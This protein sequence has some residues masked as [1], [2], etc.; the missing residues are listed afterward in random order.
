[1]SKDKGAGYILLDRKIL[2][3]WIY[4]SKPFNMTMAWIDMLLIATHTTH[5]DL[6]RGV[7]TEFKRGDVNLS[8][9][10]L[11]A[12]WGWSR[13]KAKRFLKHLEADS[14]IR[15][16]ATPRR[17]VI[18]IVNYDVFQGDRHTGKS[19]GK[20]TNKTTG[21]S[22]GESPDK[23]TGESYINND[24]N[25]ELSMIEKDPS[26]PDVGPDGYG[27]PPD[28]W[29]DEYERR[30]QED[31]PYNPGKTRQDWYEFWVLPAE[32]GDDG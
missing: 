1:M 30:F 12:R 9:K 3:S 23:S 16:N 17:T 5:T 10:E 20:S 22:T 6:W 2:N 19:T 21:K 24:I 28:G 15:I 31:A 7:P 27:V 14:M 11:A 4:K 8:I 25:N 29:T 26:P 13:D 18:T 32:D